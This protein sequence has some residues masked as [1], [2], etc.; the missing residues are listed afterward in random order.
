MAT[1]SQTFSGRSAFRLDLTVN[2]SS[3]S[4]DGNYSI[5]NIQLRIVKVSASPTYSFNNSTWSV[6]VAGV[7]YSGNF[8]YD[9]RNV[10]SLL[11]LNTD[12]QVTHNADGSQA[13]GASSVVNAALLGSAGPGLTLALTTIPRATQASLR[14]PLINAGD[15]QDITL[16]RAS[17][18]F[19]HD[20]DLLF[21]SYAKQVANR[22]T[23]AASFLIP[24]ETLNYIPNN[25]SGYGFI[26]VYTYN[27]A[28]LVGIKDTRIDI[29]PNP[30]V[31][32]EWDD[33]TVVE[34]TPGIAA[35]IGAFVRGIST[36][37]L[38]VTNPRG[39]YGATITSYKV[40]VNGQVFTT[41]T[42]KTTPLAFAGVNTITTTLT[43][44][45]GRTAT[46][47]KNI[48]VLDYSPPRILGATIQRATSQNVPD[49]MSDYIRVNMN[50]AV[51]SLMVD[52]VQ[53]NALSFKVSSRKR[54][55]TAWT[56]VISLTPGGVSYSN[57]RG[58]GPGY[59]VED[60]WEVK[61]DVTDDFMTSS[62]ILTMPTATIFM[63]WNGKLGVGIGKYHQQGSLDVIGDIY[64]RD[65]SIVQ[66]AGMIVA[67]AGTQAPPGW[68]MCN[69]A[70]LKRAT[71][72]DLY[73][74]IGLRYGSPIDSTT[75][76][77][78][79]L[80][81]K[82]VLGYDSGQTEFNSVGKVGGAKAHSHTE[83]DLSA[84]IGATGGNSLIIGYQASS[85]NPRGPAAVGAYH[86]AGSS[87]ASD[88]RAMTHHTRVYGVTAAESS[89]QPY[90]ALNYI[91]KS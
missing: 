46:R 34:G 57:Y 3:Q 66:P 38:A 59:G 49:Q 79:D 74:A 63:H 10:D 12:L 23:D 41:R 87:V 9:F 32:P 82:T 36:L 51:Q 58:I 11:L 65:G 84:A 24:L 83:G 22:V 31:L 8:T 53:K 76:I 6:V 70:F 19:T 47:T 20:V 89:L 90:M 61:L 35:N 7:N 85:L 40:T 5:V 15:I 43:D 42:A 86:V 37:Q 27:G 55:V 21:G 80:R 44:S 68:L 71:Y 33:T 81:G 25:A 88:S 50:L 56:E 52:N 4:I 67:F 91:I 73:A 69:G 28:T 39:L 13:V 60:A 45:R 26:R 17:T 18:S 75:F 2:Q 29:Q 16:P 72:P 14:Y 54:G 77:L 62:T 78:P 64:H 1:S 30:S 48:T